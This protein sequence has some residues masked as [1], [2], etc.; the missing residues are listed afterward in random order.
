MKG[1]SS[2]ILKVSFLYKIFSVFV[3]GLVVLSFGLFTNQALAEAND[4]YV[5][6]NY[7]DESNDGGHEWGVDAFATISEGLFA[8]SSGGTVHVAEGD[9]F[10]N[11]SITLP[12]TI[13]GESNALVTVTAPFAS[14][15]GFDI[16]A[17]DVTISGFTITGATGGGGG[18]KAGISINSGVDGITISNNIIFGNMHGIKTN[19]NVNNLNITNSKIINNSLYGIK[20][21]ASTTGVSSWTINNNE[22]SE[23]IGLNIFNGFD[24]DVLNAEYNWWGTDVKDEIKSSLIANSG[25]DFVPFWENEEKTTPS[26]L[27]YTLSVCA[28]GCDYETIMEAIG[29]TDYETSTDSVSNIINVQAGN[30]SETFNIRKPVI[31]KGPNADISPINGVRVPEAVLG[32]AEVGENLPPIIG[33]TTDNVSNITIEGFKFGGTTNSAIPGIIYS[34]K[35]NVNNVTIKNNIFA[36]SDGRS[37]FTTQLGEDEYRDNWLITNNIFENIG[38]GT[39]AELGTTPNP[40]QSAMMINNIEN[41]SITNNQIDTTSYGGIQ[42][43]YSSN[44]TIS[45]NTVSNVPRSGIQV[46]YSSDITVE[47]NTVTNA[48]NGEPMTDTRLYGAH[49]DDQTEDGGITIYNG[50]QTNIIVQDNTLD[51]NFNGIKVRGEGSLND[52]EIIIRRNSIKNSINL[53]IENLAEGIL[54]MSDNSW[55][56][57]FENLL[58]LFSNNGSLIIP[59][60]ESIDAPSQISFNEETIIGITEESGG[61]TV[62][63]PAGTIITRSTEG[64]IDLSLMGFSRCANIRIVWINFWINCERGITIWNSRN[65]INI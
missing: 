59:E 14:S 15:H 45:G 49:T 19:G 55:Y 21:P 57:K 23:N 62:V 1:M 34:N 38:T 7:T 39:D 16:Y 22:F 50:F 46:A 31:L 61:S 8:V 32:T 4:V 47:D 10:G 30:Y 48:G 58:T 52:N 27:T 51:G 64:T 33:L 63:L 35:P 13:L 18:G 5:D 24:N 56:V 11:I 6:D 36:D 25:V 60:G 9:Y 44:T 42:L 43:G 40:F 37:I 20:I 12:V 3:L 28:S 53:G 29:N 26:L 65:R 17:S 41:S 54:D 2:S